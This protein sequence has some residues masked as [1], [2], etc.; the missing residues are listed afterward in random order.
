MPA[1]AAG[2]A[3]ESAAV[4]AAR[5]DGTAWEALATSVEG[6]FAGEH[7]S[8]VVDPA[9]GSLIVTGNFAR[10]DGVRANGIARLREGTW[11]PVGDGLEADQLV[12]DA[13]FH[14]GALF[15]SG[16]F[17]RTGGGT[18]A[19]N[20]VRLAGGSFEAVG[21]PAGVFAGKLTSVGGG[22]FEKGEA[23]EID[24]SPRDARREQRG[25]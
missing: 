19:P 20:V 25:M 6:A 14:E 3:K 10:I 11:E 17:D 24:V 1:A 8:V 22:L 18:A 9:D 21:A 5:W 12:E 16:W 13:I 23:R 7:R 2:R 15:V 4:A